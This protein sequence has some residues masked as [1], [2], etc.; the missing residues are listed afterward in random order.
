MKK[1]TVNHGC[2]FLLIN[3]KSKHTFYKKFDRVYI[4]SNSLHTISTK[5]KLPDDRMFNGI[6]D[7]ENVVNELKQNDFKTLIIL[8]D[9][10]SDIK[11]NDFFKSLIYNR[12]HIGGGISIILM[13]QVYNKLQ[14]DLR[15][16]ASHLVMFNSTNKKE[17]ISIFEDFV[18]TKKETFLDVCNY[19]FDKKHN[20]LFLDVNNKLFY[21]NFNLLSII[22]N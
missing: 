9:V 14:L 11:S 18:N 19:V 17:L 4:F 1:K 8:D 20:F 16:A 12:R 15:K 10:I 13:T 21:K 5:I 2:G 22:E 7:I 6:D 3:K